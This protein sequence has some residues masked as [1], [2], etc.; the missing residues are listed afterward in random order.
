MET[1]VR[2][3]PTHGTNA[4]DFNLITVL[5]MDGFGEGIPVARK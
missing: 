5:V 3:D 1:C 2:M 4:Y